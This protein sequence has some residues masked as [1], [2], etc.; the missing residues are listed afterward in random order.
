MPDDTATPAATFDPSSAIRSDTDATL[1]LA[2]WCLRKSFF[3]MLWLGLSF[4]TIVLVLINHETQTATERLASL[5]SPDEYLRAL[6]SPMA[7]VVLA[8]A[9]RISVG[10]LALAAA[11]PLTASAS[12]YEYP[13]AGRLGHVTRRWF[14]KLY[15]TRGYRSLRWTWTVRNEAARQ[16]GRRGEILS[17]CSRVMRWSAIVLFIVYLAILVAAGAATASS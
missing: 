1:V 2:L 15:I 11:Y 17:T 10:F 8:L 14:D 7:L 4:A 9:I 16:I 12:L 13:D 6:V 3:P 5:D